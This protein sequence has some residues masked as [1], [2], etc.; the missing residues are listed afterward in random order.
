MSEAS[1]DLYNHA[2][3]AVQAGQLEKAISFTEE[4]LTEDPADTLTW[5]LYVKLLAAAGRTQDATRAAEKLK[6]L[7]LG[8]TESLMIDAAKQ[9]AQGDIDAA[10]ATF[11]AASELEPRN[12]E[13]HASRAM[14]LLQ[15]GDTKAALQAARTA[16]G[17]APSDSRANYALGHLLRITEEKAEALQV[18]TTAL[19]DE[20]D[21]TPALYEQGMLLA[22]GGRL[23]D[24]LANFEKFAT[25]H[26]DDPNARTAIQNIKTALGKNHTP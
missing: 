17:L 1:T 20:P 9:I 23:E 25:F 15:K 18:L 7:G 8:E 13:I 14:A 2:I 22:E 24:A 11:E 21:F 3:D 5:Q 16:V 12:A 10:I 6:A 19:A 26:P 4:A